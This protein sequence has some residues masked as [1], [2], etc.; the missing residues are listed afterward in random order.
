MK[1]KFR[2]DRPIYAQLVEQL[3]RGILSGE[4]PPGAQVPSVR[5]LAL[6]A[7][8]NPNTMQRALAELEM[9]GLLRTHRT[10][11]RTV[12]D[13]QSMIDN[14][15]QSLAQAHIEA[16]FEGMFDIGFGEKE[17]LKWIASEAKKRPPRNDRNIE[18]V[19]S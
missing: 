8:V 13:D 10:T 2:G 18:E 6:E 4:F 9:L 14:A 3:Q 11:G 15:K 12:T 17:A 16:F 5:T 1:W 19:R 7:E